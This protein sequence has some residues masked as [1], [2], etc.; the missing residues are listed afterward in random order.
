MIISRTPLRASFFGGGSDLG[1]YYRNSACGYG[2]VL[3]TAIDMYIYITVNKK[4]DDQIRVSYSKT[5]IVDS[6]DQIKHNIIQEALKIA[7]IEKGIEIV[8]MGDVPLGSA[9]VGLASSSALA[10]GVLNALFAYQGRA[11]SAE[12][13]AQKACEIEIDRLKNPIGKQDQYAV[14][15]GGFHHYRFNA[16]ESVFVNPL[17]CQ[18]QVKQALQENLM[19]FYT[20]MTHISSH[21]LREQKEN[22]PEKMKNL[23]RMVQMSYEAE[24]LLQRNALDEFGMLLD[25]AW[26]LKKQLASSISDPKIDEMYVAAR[27]AGALGGKIL[28]AGGGGFMML[29]VPEKY[30]QSVRK[31]LSQY[32]EQKVALDL[33]GSKIIYVR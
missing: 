28:G 22:I 29:Y 31:A 14:A 4:F 25:E 18:P 3:S 7:G 15:Y 33:E 32:R 1:D 23:D 19:F 17:I 27:G 21:I 9:G 20:N 2:A 13:L 8:Y 6:V 26:R 30:R 10:V 16:D 24:R 12:F 5:E 11:V